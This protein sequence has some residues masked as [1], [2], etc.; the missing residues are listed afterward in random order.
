MSVR[1][2]QT[3]WNA[4]GEGYRS[5]DDQT[6]PYLA[7]SASWAAWWVGR[8]YGLGRVAMSRGCSLRAEIDQRERVLTFAEIESLAT[9]PRRTPVITYLHPETV[10]TETAYGRTAAYPFSVKVF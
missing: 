7:T 10:S 9:L 2:D 5:D 8:A 1:F 4:R 6:C 3:L